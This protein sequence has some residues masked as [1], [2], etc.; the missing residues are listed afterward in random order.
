M[1][2]GRSGG[3]ISFPGA[4]LIII[5]VN[6]SKRIKICIIIIVIW[7]AFL[8]YGNKFNNFLGKGFFNDFS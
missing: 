1:R 4:I 7:F 2:G 6:F 8:T 3:F 5:F